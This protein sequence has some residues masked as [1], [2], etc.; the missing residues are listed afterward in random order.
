MAFLP[1]PPRATKPM[2]QDQDEYDDEWNKF[3]EAMNEKGNEVESRQFW[4]LRRLLNTLQGMEEDLELSP[5]FKLFNDRWHLVCRDGKFELE[6]ECD[7]DTPDSPDDGTPCWL[8]FNP[9]KFEESRSYLHNL[10]MTNNAFKVAA[11]ILPVD[12][13]DEDEGYLVE[14]YNM[15]GHNKLTNED[16]NTFCYVVSLALQVTN[17]KM[18]L[19]VLEWLGKCVEATPSFEADVFFFQLPIFE[20][21]FFG[22]PSALGQAACGIYAARKIFPQ[23]ASWTLP[24]SAESA[25]GERTLKRSRSE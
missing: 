4:Q 18:Q 14:I 8:W 24:E 15:T 3:E 21:F 2:N 6:V 17:P 9:D 12:D 5:K 19:F 1:T 7:E 16:T 22:R 20:K 11:G 10:P 23:L 13:E 25:E